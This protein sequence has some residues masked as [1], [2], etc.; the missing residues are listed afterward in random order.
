MEI[1][2]EEWDGVELRLSLRPVAK[3]EGEIFIH[4][5]EGFGTPVTDGAVASP[6]GN[7]VWSIGLR[8]DDATALVPRFES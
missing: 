6:K 4:V 2:S 3:A 8:L 1:A 7:G 5:P